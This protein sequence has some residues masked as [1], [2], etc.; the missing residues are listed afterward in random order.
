MQVFS[1]TG[2]DPLTAVTEAVAND[3]G[4][5]GEYHF[6]LQKNPVGDAAQPAGID[7]GMI[8]AGIFMEDSTNGQ[9]TLSA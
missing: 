5:L 2:N 3:L 7:E 9:V 8:F 1:S 6:S 4:G